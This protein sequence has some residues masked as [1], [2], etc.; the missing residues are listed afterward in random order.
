[1]IA[2]IADNPRP[3]LFPVSCSG[4]APKAVL[5]GPWD[6]A[7]SQEK[8]VL[9]ELRAAVEVKDVNGRDEQLK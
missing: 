1:M 2:C 6:E 4:A 7:L 3:V 5:E 9:H 8:A